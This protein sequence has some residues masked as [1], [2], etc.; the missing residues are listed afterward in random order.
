MHGIPN[1]QGVFIV[2]NTAKLTLPAQTIDTTQ[3]VGR[4]L[5]ENAKAQMGAIPNMYAVMV[6][7]PGLLETYL[8]GYKRFREDGGFAPVEQEVVLLTIS[9]FNA[10]TYC[11]AAHSKIAD[12]M[13]KMPAQVLAALRSGKPIP[14]PQ[15]AALSSFTEVMLA[16][17]GNPWEEQLS[18][19]KAA[20][21]GERQ[22]LQIILAIAVKTLSNY[23]N[24]L[25]HT[26]VDGRFQ[27]YAWEP[28]S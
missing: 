9:R 1:L 5:L 3:G 24:H 7:S 23:S 8:L 10:C 17:R 15:L 25:F 11:M 4:S 13:S 20:G 2:S 6:N 27:A 26:N 21:Y 14:D 12:K 19:F 22:V 16:Q 18:E 28:E